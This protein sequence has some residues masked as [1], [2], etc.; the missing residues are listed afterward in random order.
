MRI[1]QLDERNGITVIETPSYDIKEF[2]NEIIKKMGYSN[3]KK[4]DLYEVAPKGMY[5]LTVEQSEK[6]LD[7]IIE[8]NI[9]KPTYVLS[10]KINNAWKDFSERYSLIN[11]PHT[12]SPYGKSEAL[13]NALSLLSAT[14]ENS[15]QYIPTKESSYFKPVDYKKFLLETIDNIKKQLGDSGKL[16]YD[17]D[18]LK[19]IIE[20]SEKPSDTLDKIRQVFNFQVGIYGMPAIDGFSDQVYNM[21]D[22]M[23]GMT[24]VHKKA[25]MLKGII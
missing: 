4:D 14:K 24:D 10:H 21:V 13:F 25:M 12:Y 3:L 5:E 9:G 16:D 18:K 15:W 1:S 8:E 6:T 17:I 20:Q 7:E 11:M 22:A 23:L 2:T 19:E